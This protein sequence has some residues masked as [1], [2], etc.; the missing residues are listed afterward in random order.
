MAITQPESGLT[1]SQYNALIQQ[2]TA[3]TFQV[4]AHKTNLDFESVPGSTVDTNT[5]DDFDAVAYYNYLVRIA[6]DNIEVYD[7]EA[8]QSSWPATFPADRIT[9][10]KPALAVDTDSIALFC[11]CAS[12]LKVRHFHIMW[13]ML[14]WDDDWTTIR[15]NTGSFKY[16]GANEALQTTPTPGKST[17]LAN[18]ITTSAPYMG[19]D[20]KYY[21]FFATAWA[22]NTWLAYRFDAPKKIKRYAI[23]GRGDIDSYPEWAGQNPK[24]W[25]LQYSTDLTKAWAATTGAANI[26]AA[27]TWVTVDTRAGVTFGNNERKLFDIEYADPNNIPEV[28]WWRILVTA[29]NGN[30]VLAIVE[31]ELMPEVS[32]TVQPITYIAATTPNRVHYLFTDGATGTYQP[33]CAEFA[34]NTWTERQSDIYWPYTPS[35]F[36]ATALPSG[37]DV[38]AMTSNTPGVMT[39]QTSGTKTV[40]YVYQEGGIVAFRYANDTWSDHEEVD[41]ADYVTSWRFRKHVRATTLGDKA[42]LVAYVSDGSSE[43]PIADY[44]V[45]ASNDGMNWT[46]GEPLPVQFTGGYG[47]K[48]LRAG[49]YLYAVER[50]NLER[51]L[52]TLPYG[53]SAPGCQADITDDIDELEVSQSDMTQVGMTVDNSDGAYTNHP[54]LS[55][56][57][58]VVLVIRGGYQLPQTAT[59]QLCLVEVDTIG[60]DETLP[61][62]YLRVT[63]RDVMAR[64]TDRIKA[65]YPRRWH[66]QM[67]GA[68]KY[69]ENIGSNYGGLGHTAVVTGNWEASAGE[70]STEVKSAEAIAFSSLSSETL[71]NATHQIAFEVQD[72][73]GAAVPGTAGIKATY[74]ERTTVV[75][76]VDTQINHPDYWNPMNGDPNWDT[77]WFGTFTGYILTPAYAG[78]YTFYLEKDDGGVL[79][80]NGKTL[81]NRW[82]DEVG[83]WSANITLPAS[84][85]VPFTLRYYQKQQGARLILKWAYS[86]TP[87]SVI[88]AA[89]FFQTVTFSAPAERYAGVCFRAIDQSNLWFAAF[90]PGDNKVKLARRV[91]GRD[92]V[93]AEST[94]MGTLWP[95]DTKYLRVRCHYANIIVYAS[96]DGI[97]W[98]P[99]ITYRQDCRNRTEP[100]DEG[101]V[102]VTQAIPERGSVGFIVKES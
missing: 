72:A 8:F 18:T 99:I 41:M 29:N 21:T 78:T 32:G 71:W 79:T 96:S 53:Y 35:S 30:S 38:I 66:H 87:K 62:N 90:Y 58:N 13:G 20:G 15:D 95:N 39:A 2:E 94:S 42:Y 85:Y 7:D 49:D 81:I 51:A 93:V 60:H 6:G 80:V 97:N 76:R 48:L 10:I 40:S 77:Q 63:A 92:Y 101:L 67:L 65:R 47:A 14:F 83:E 89:N 69:E 68:D 31:L 82:Y 91:D 1:E 24:N 55:E 9:T 17:G 25:Q 22:A 98:T 100:N 46:A 45:Y 27:G 61:E 3:P 70:L 54:I 34:D 16:I 26:P 84:T 4:V 52:S 64:F 75:N 88:P 57:N 28:I 36:A 12:G 50:K 23:V 74:Q 43:Y 86:T 102:T 73:T 5:G 33:R 56:Q 59:I 37:V 44:Q 11:V 19:F